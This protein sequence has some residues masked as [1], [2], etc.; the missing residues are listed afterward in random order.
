MT[1]AEQGADYVMFGDAQDGK[2]ASFDAI[3][4]RVAWWAEVFEIPCVAMAQSFD[5]VGPLAAAGADFVAVG[6]FIW[7]DKRGVTAALAAAA[8][9]TPETVA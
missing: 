8:Q 2:R 1:A 6:D 5:E 7:N 3:V 4:E 9:F